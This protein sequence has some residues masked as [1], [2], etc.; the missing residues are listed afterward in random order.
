MDMPNPQTYKI[1]GGFVAFVEVHG[2][3]V[4]GR[5]PTEAGARADLQKSLELH[6]RLVA[7][8]ETDRL[9]RRPPLSV[10]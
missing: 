3:R 4:S 5:G 1:A 7:R 10:P 8:V 6:D 2:H 9:A